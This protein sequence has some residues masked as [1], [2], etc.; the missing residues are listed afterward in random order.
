MKHDLR[1]FHDVSGDVAAGEAYRQAWIPHELAKYSGITVVRRTVGMDF[2][3][4]HFTAIDEADAVLAE[5][6]QP[7]D[8]LQQRIIYANMAG[9]RI[10]VAVE[11][12]QTSHKLLDRFPAPF[13]GHITS[14]EPAKSYWIKDPV[15]HTR[16][17]SVYHATMLQ[18]IRLKTWLGSFDV[19]TEADRRREAEIDKRLDAFDAAL[20]AHGEKGLLD[21]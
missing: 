11:K 9:K 14:K 7:D 10:L 12:T 17:I 15:Y 4:G 3:S 13:P 2:E 18:D 6:N 21:D 16:D 1:I 5:F 8:E 20:R 19:L